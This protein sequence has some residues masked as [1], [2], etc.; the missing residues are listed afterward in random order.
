MAE[1]RKIFHNQKQTT[2]E[3]W[4]KWDYSRKYIDL[5]KVLNKEKSQIAKS[6]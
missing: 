1:I 2:K 3:K 6:N 4:V 5:R